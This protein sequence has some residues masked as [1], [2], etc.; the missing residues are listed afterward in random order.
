MNLATLINAAGT[1]LFPE[2]HAARKPAITERGTRILLSDA[3]LADQLLMKPNTLGVESHAE[4]P[5]HERYELMHVTAH[6]AD[7]SP[8]KVKHM[9]SASLKKDNLNQRDVVKV[10][11]APTHATMTWRASSRCRMCR[12]RRTSP[13]TRFTTNV[14]ASC[15]LV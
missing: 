4:Y 14:W 12:R 9:N 6:R 5:H 10:L 3:M 13:S 1:P 2:L 8:P 15:E 7:G 11:T